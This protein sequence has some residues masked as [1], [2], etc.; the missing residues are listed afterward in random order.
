MQE[1]TKDKGRAIDWKALHNISEKMTSLEQTVKEKVVPLI[2]KHDKALYSEDGT[3]GLVRD[4]YTVKVG[5]REHISSHKWWITTLIGI[6]SL[7][8]VIVRLIK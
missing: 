3:N 7:F 8:V 6:C 1:D 2:E 5:F 4:V